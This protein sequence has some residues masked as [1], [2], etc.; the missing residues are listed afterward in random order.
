MEHNWAD[1]YTFTGGVVISYGVYVSA[2]R[3]TYIITIY[4][5]ESR[6]Q[7]QYCRPGKVVNRLQWTV[8]AGS[9]RSVVPST[10]TPRGHRKNDPV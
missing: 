4:C 1:L 8:S 6:L 2:C 9:N 7:V 3:K 5:T 10:P